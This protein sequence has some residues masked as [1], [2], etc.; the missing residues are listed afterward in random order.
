MTAAPAPLH[1][2]S[3]APLPRS[4]V[5]LVRRCDGELLAAQLAS[6]PAERF[7]HGHLA[8]LRLAGAVL[9]A[10]VHRPARPAR[11]SAWSRLVALEPSLAPWARFFE[12]GASVRSAIDAGRTSAVD[13]ALASRWVAAAE[14]FR[15]AVCVHLGID[16]F[17]DLGQ[18]LRRA[19]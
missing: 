2:T 10:H 7:T 8:A 5:E 18:S 9:E 1:P 12:S 11:G 13:D 19:S 4:V 15:D 16:P 14:D 17:G 3:T 6:D